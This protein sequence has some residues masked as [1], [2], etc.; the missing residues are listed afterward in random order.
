MK[1]FS[2]SGI[3][4]EIKR[5]RWPK[6]KDLMRNTGS[7]VLFTIAFGVFFVICDAFAYMFLQILGF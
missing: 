6:P 4:S 3:L 5:V 2:L 7:V 1:W